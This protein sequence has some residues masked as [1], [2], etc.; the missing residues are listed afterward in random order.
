MGPRHLLRGARLYAP[1]LRVQFTENTVV[2]GN[3]LWNWNGSCPVTAASNRA[4]AFCDPPP[5]GAWDSADPW[6]PRARADPYPHPK[7]VEPYFIGVLGSD[8]D[9]QP[10]EPYPHGAKGPCT[11]SAPAA[12]QGP[13]NQLVVIQRNRVLNNGGVVVRGVRACESNPPRLHIL[14]PGSH[15]CP[16]CVATQHTANVLVEANVMLNSSVQRVHVNRTHASNVLV[17][18]G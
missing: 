14:D 15:S 12:W 1:N 16:A 10:C 4:R 7:T 11:P 8:Q 18:E 9:S 5:K 13:I 3:H 6:S 17:A 2:E